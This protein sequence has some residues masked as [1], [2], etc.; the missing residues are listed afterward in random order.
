MNCRTDIPTCCAR[1]THT[2]RAGAGSILGFWIGNVDL[3]Y[4]FSFLG[5][6]QV[7][8]LS[9]F[10]SL[11]LVGCHAITCLCVEERV[12]LDENRTIP[13]V[14][15]SAGGTGDSSGMP[16]NHE[17]EEV[18]LL[19]PTAFF[20]RERTRKLLKPARE[21]LVQIWSTYR[22]LPDPIWH[23]CKVQAF[24]WGGWFPI[25]YVCLA[26]RVQKFSLLLSGS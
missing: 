11:A 19:R 24:A 17:E 1:V 21:S 26:F 3:T 18:G 12:L 4:A 10:A 25:L 2:R 8:I 5:S 7:K 15:S 13:L 14:S 9:V 16:L 6:T 23:I 22:T 20:T